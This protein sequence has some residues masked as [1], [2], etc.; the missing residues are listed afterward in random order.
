[1]DNIE[2]IHQG[3]YSASNL[4]CPRAQALHILGHKAVFPKKLLTKFEEGQE[5]DEEMKKEAEEEF[6]D[7]HVP[8]SRIIKLTR[9]STTAE[10]SLTPDGLR[11]EE[12]V[13]FKG[14]APSFWNSLNTEEDLKTNSDLTKKYYQQ[15][16]AYAGAFKK[17]IIRFRIKNKGNLKTKDIVFKAD[18]KVWE[19][20]KNTVMDIQEFLDKQT[21]PP[22]EC[23]S[24]TEKRCFFRKS[25]MTERAK[26]VE[27]TETKP[28]TPKTTSILTQQVNSYL[29]LKEK[30]EKL[31]E[32]KGKLL[33]EIKK[34][35]KKHGQREQELVPAIVK[36]GIRY[37]EQKNKED[38]ADLVEAG[39]I[40]VEQAPEEY[41]AVYAKGKE[42]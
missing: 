5:H 29:G 13:E 21:L 23:P 20:I 41:C 6:K 3:R 42:E 8:D 24:N 36:Y 35:M 37:K 18:S 33:A 22:K 11:D 40:R 31:E 32:D 28:L 9:D 25:C 7:F 14:L 12:V 10:M 15:V 38:I 30:I 4:G 16:Q 34:I 1:M 2:R 27:M 17:R 39:K 19:D 26:E